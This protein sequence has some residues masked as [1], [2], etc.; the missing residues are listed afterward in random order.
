MGILLP[1][2][3]L[4]TLI[5]G[6][7]IGFGVLV[8]LGEW[9]QQ[10]LRVMADVLL[11]IFVLLPVVLV[12]AILDFLLIMLAWGNGQIPRFLVPILRFIRRTLLRSAGWAN[13]GSEWVIFPIIFIHR[14]L[15]SL[16]AFLSE[17]LMWFEGQPESANDPVTTENDPQTETETG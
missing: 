3:G 12:M 1:L 15:A 7:I 9:S 8:L 11:I 4:A 6:L 2:V 17:L 16:S 10:Q 5:S 13:R 14:T